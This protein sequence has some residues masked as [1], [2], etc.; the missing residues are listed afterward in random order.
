MIFG[1]LCG[2]SGQY[3][4]DKIEDGAQASPSPGMEARQTAKLHKKIVALVPV[5]NTGYDLRESIP[6]LG[7]HSQGG[8]LASMMPALGMYRRFLFF[9][10]PFEES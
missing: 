6:I 2:A 5:S 8:K 7:Q 10:L 4:L 1:S 9:W 3:D